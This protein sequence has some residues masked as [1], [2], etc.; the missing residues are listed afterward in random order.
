[1]KTTAWGVNGHLLFQASPSAPCLNS[2]IWSPQSPKF[3]RAPSALSTP[4]SPDSFPENR[5][6]VSLQSWAADELLVRVKEHSLGKK[7]E[8]KPVWPSE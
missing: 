6:R 1:M 4:L 8:P 2:R 5:R 3:P 7:G